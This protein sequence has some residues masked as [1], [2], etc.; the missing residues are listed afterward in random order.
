MKQR[1]CARQSG[2][3]YGLW[4]PSF[5][6]GSFFIIL[7]YILYVNKAFKF[8]SN[9]QINLSPDES[10]L[11][12]KISSKI[13]EF[14][15]WAFSGKSRTGFYRKT[16]CLCWNDKFSAQKYAF[17]GLNMWLLARMSPFQHPYF[18]LEFGL[19]TMQDMAAKHE[20]GQRRWLRTLQN[21][22]HQFIKIHFLFQIL[23]STRIQGL[24]AQDVPQC[25]FKAKTTLHPLA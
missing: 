16:W 24:R 19:R 22:E 13:L 20:A 23:P 6:T 8:V 10:I 15:F 14:R 9:F 21:I 17:Q 2:Y 18:L 7:Y 25:Y 3:V 5:A 1:C 11:Y 12:C 4:Q